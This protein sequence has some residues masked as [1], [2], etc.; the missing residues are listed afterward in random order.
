MPSSLTQSAPYLLVAGGV[1]AAVLWVWRHRRAQG[2][3]PSAAAAGLA[4]M[5]SREFEAIVGEAF[6]LQGYQ[7]AV[8]AHGSEMIL[9]RARESF[10]VQCSHWRDGKVDR[11]VGAPW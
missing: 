10:L 8:D 5:S 2:D 6:R 1:T 9:R 11:L 7:V 3:A 4:G